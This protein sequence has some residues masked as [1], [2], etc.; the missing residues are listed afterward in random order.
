MSNKYM[1]LLLTLIFSAIAL[2]VVSQMDKGKKK[3]DPKNLFMGKGQLFDLDSVKGRLNGIFFGM[4]V[5]LIGWNIDD[6]GRWIWYQFG[7]ELLVSQQKEAWHQTVAM[8]MGLGIIT[9]NIVQLAFLIRTRRRECRAQVL[10]SSNSSISKN[11]ESPT[12]F[13]DD[14]PPD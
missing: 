14:G 11:K 2:V 13:K 3:D 6:I 8:V 7:N 5:C 4:V 9:I 10:Q 1:E 12:T